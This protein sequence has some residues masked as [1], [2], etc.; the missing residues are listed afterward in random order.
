LA[1][2]H[3]FINQFNNY[4]H[5]SAASAKK[6]RCKLKIFSKDKKCGFRGIPGCRPEG[7]TY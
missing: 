1:L 7:Q 6:I 3:E 5:F 4:E 2:S